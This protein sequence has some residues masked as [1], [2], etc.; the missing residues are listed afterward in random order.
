MLVER[1]LL[2]VFFP[3][4]K[5]SSSRRVWRRVLLQD[6]ISAVNEEITQLK[7]HADDTKKHLSLFRHPKE[8]VYGFGGEL[9]NFSLRVFR[10]GQKHVVTVLAILALIAAYF[11]AEQI[12]GRPQ[13]V[14]LMVRGGS[15]ATLQIAAYV[16]DIAYWVFLGFLSS[17]GL[18]MS[19][20][21]ISPFC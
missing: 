2:V 18:G 3:Q 9:A 19:Y 10:L 15:H 17:F 12:P 20:P 6:L 16:Y 4:F 8:V 5:K 13:R 11:V 14:R 7:K 1:H 21:D